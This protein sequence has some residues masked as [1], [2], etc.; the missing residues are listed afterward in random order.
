MLNSKK[1]SARQ[2]PVKAVVDMSALAFNKGLP[3][4]FSSFFALSIAHYTSY[5]SCPM[6]WTVLFKYNKITNALGSKLQLQ[7]D[8]LV[9]KSSR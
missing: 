9:V 4:L 5:S 8:H 1:A 2:I 7:T 3:S 6:H